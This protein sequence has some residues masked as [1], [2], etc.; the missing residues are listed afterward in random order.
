MFNW[1]VAGQHDKNWG[2]VLYVKIF[3]MIKI[4]LKSYATQ[5]PYFFIEIESPFVQDSFRQV[6]VKFKDLSRT[7]KDF[8]DISRTET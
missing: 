8:P 1:N 5:D 6:S 2:G 3:S 7:S 4:N